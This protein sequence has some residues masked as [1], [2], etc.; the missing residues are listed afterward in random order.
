MVKGAQTGNEKLQAST[1]AKRESVD[2]K[3]EDKFDG[4][5]EDCVM[6]VGLARCHC[7]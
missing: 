4:L 7:P 2:V 3:K 1:G 6:Y 5:A